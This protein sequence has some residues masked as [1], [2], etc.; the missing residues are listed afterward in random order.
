M[1][2]NIPITHLDRLEKQVQRIRN[3]GASVVFDVG[4]EIYIEDSKLPGVFHKC[5]QV[6]V[7]GSYRV[8]GWDFVA[9]IE[10]AGD[11]NIIRAVNDGLLQ[12]MPDYYLTCSRECEH[13][14]KI[15]DRK[16][17]Y[18][19]RNTSTGEWKQVGRTCLLDYTQGLDA[20]TCALLASFVDSCRDIQTEGGEDEFLKGGYKRPASDYVSGLAAKKVAYKWVQD[21]GYIKDGVTTQAVAHQIYENPHAEEASDQEIEAVDAWVQT[22]PDNN[23]YFWNAKAAWE[24]PYLEARDLGLISSLISVYFKQQAEQARREAEARRNA[25]DPSNITVGQ[26]GDR[27]TIKAKQARILYTKDNGYKSYYAP[28]SYVWE[29]ID[30]EGHT[31]IWSASTNDIQAGDTI[32]ATVKEFKEFRGRK[33]T[34]ITRGKVERT[35]SAD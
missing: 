21:H 14:H 11:R 22:L 23:A 28:N 1:V 4:P 31:F 9:T 15:R 8:N 13:C 19:I 17:T 29:I 5:R 25:A 34:V 6:D 16:D 2:Y 27:I 3:K 24:R 32:T 18:L 33:Q 20:E 35:S 26:V 12:D 10:H 30:E 7:E